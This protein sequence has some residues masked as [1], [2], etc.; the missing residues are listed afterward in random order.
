MLAKRIIPCLD[1][2]DGRV[3]KGRKF[4]E[5]RDVAD[6]V[7][8]GKR[9]SEEGA[10]ELVFYDITA[11]HQKRGIFLDVVERLRGG[12]ELDLRGRS[13]GPAL[14]RAEQGHDTH[15]SEQPGPPHQVVP[16]RSRSTLIELAHQAA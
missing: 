15:P 9:Y 11:S 13:L 3:V 14:S 12:V 5:I 2:D 6:P 1:V 10:D 8:L 16:L 7:D 4:K